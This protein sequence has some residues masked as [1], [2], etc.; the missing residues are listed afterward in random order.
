MSSYVVRVH[1]GAL[2]DPERVVTIREAEVLR[3][4][5]QGLRKKEMASLMYVSI[6]TVEKHIDSVM[7]KLRIHDRV[8]LARYAIREKLVTL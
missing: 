1:T 6:K 4:V 5:A 8:E 2:S 7:R 3:Y